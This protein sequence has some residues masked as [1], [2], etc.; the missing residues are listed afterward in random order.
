MRFRQPLDARDL[1]AF[2]FRMH[3]IDVRFG[4]SKPLTNASGFVKT[5]LLNDVGTNI[6]RSGGSERNV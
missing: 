3:D 2:L 5:E 6:R 4:R 1:F